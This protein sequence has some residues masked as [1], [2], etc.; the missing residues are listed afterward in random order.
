MLPNTT[1]SA[2]YSIFERID[3]ALSQ[4]VNLQPLDIVVNLDSHIGG[5]EYKDSMSAPELLESANTALEQAR[6]SNNGRV[7]ISENN[8]R[9][10][11]G[12]RVISA[13]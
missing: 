10:V 6:R 7:Y 4:P 2:A 5:A 1:G 9:A 11:K 3:V 12:D 8:K 13:S